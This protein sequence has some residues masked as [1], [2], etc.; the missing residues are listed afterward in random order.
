MRTKPLNPNSMSMIMENFKRYQKVLEAEFG[1]ADNVIYLFEDNRKVPTT[2][3]TEQLLEDYDSGKITE[4]KLAETWERSF[5]YEA[6]E[7]A[8]LLE[9]WEEEARRQA[10]EADECDVKFNPQACSPEELAAAGEGEEGG[11]YEKLGLLFNKAIDWM[12]GVLRRGLNLVLKGANT[13]YGWLIEFKKKHPLLFKIIVATIII[14]IAVAVIYAIFAVVQRLLE[15]PNIQE[16]GIAAVP[17]CGQAAAAAVAGTSLQEAQGGC[18]ANGIIIDAEQFKIAQ[19]IMEKMKV[20]AA[21]DREMVTQLD[22]AQDCLKQCFE[23]AQ[24]GKTI[25]L[26]DVGGGGNMF[27][28]AATGMVGYTRR[29]MD[30]GSEIKAAGM[31]AVAKAGIAPGKA[32]ASDS[33]LEAELNSIGLDMKAAAQTLNKLKAA[34]KDGGDYMNRVTPQIHKTLQ[35]QQALY[36]PDREQ[37]LK[38]AQAAQAGMSKADVL[39]KLQ[40]DM[41]ESKG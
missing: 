7:V 19:G 16:K 15:D 4:E 22:Y 37:A 25:N 9:G 35:R 34:A 31:R 2:T 33:A 20:E 28:R 36:S 1:E 23:A 14:A 30:E 24:E 12:M 3:S 27:A 6:Q 38:Q 41:K 17:L 29:L 8:R 21:G 10:I 18:F 32:R 13:V 40:A 5:N 11:A 26:E 39:A